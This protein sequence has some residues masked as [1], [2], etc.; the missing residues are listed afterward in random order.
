MVLAGH[1][2]ENLEESRERADKA[3]WRE[4]NRGHPPD[5]EEGAGAQE[6]AVARADSVQSVDLGYGRGLR[7]FWIRICL[8]S[9][10]PGDPR[11]AVSSLST[12]RGAL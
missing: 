11:F 1:F 7:P 3:L 12:V 9:F 6:P 8:M 4:R 5:G 2:S 10:P